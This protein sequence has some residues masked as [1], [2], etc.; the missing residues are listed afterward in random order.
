[1]C[2]SISVRTYDGK[3]NKK[4]MTVGKR[5]NG[6]LLYRSKH[7]YLCLMDESDKA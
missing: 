7:L 3:L 1:M 5:E 4:H 2:N 6:E